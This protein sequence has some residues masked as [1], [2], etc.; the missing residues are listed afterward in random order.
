M[1][2]NTRPTT[3]TDLMYKMKEFLVSP[4]NKRLLENEHLTVTKVSWDD[5]SRDNNS[6]VGSNVSDI[7]LKIDDYL[8]PIIRY[9]NM[10][11]ITVDFTDKEFPIPKEYL[12]H[13]NKYVSTDQE[14]LNLWSDKDKT[15]LVSAQACILPL[16]N[17]NVEFV[18]NLFNYQ[19][20]N[21]QPAILAITVS[22]G[23]I[24]TQVVT[25]E[26][27]LYFDDNGVAK[28]YKAE[29]GNVVTYGTDVNDN[30]LIIIQVPL[31][32]KVN[33]D[34]YFNNTYYP[35]SARSSMASSQTMAVSRSMAPAQISTGTSSGFVFPGLK[36]GNRFYHIE[37][38]HE[39]PI[40]VTYQFYNV[41]DNETLSADEVRELKKQI[42][43]IYDKGNNKGS[44]STTG[45]P[46]IINPLRKE[47]T[48][49]NGKYRCYLTN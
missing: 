46:L 42:T 16:R 27:N 43:S 4:E 35:F 13:L 49:G 18:P 33:P 2:K 37:R 22:K 9:N 5:V 8:M 21:N 14:N 48:G 3:T 29:R 45:E 25:N 1:S 20:Q 36:N 10:S 11:D 19:S 7:T 26:R 39:R 47:Q 34:S 41:T 24:S 31:K 30:K 28:T 32:Q 6:N 17:G 40:R 15:F 38:D 12:M 23:G 44:I